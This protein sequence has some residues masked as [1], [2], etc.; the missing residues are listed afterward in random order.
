MLPC[1]SYHRLLTTHNFLTTTNQA[2]FRINH[3]KMKISKKGGTESYGGWSLSP[4]FPPCAD[5]ASA[6]PIIFV[7]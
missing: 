5:L 7:S 1:L 6:F 2:L 3:R 4:S